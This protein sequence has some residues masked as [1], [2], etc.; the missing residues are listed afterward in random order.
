M[1]ISCS[2]N[3]SL[4][5]LTDMMTWNDDTL[6][7]SVEG[8]GDS[9]FIYVNSGSCGPQMKHDETQ[10]AWWEHGSDLAEQSLLRADEPK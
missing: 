4:K 9:S 8:D 7:T 1:I 5:L 3:V 2:F 10:E 6:K